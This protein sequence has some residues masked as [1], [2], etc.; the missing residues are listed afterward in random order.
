[1]NK[2]D[3]KKRENISQKLKKKFFLF[4][5]KRWI[6]ATVI[7]KEIKNHQESGKQKAKGYYENN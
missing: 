1:M 7:I 6:I 2:N 3:F 5:H 4:L